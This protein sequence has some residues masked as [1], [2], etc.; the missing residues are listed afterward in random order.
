MPDR[1][2]FIADELPIPVYSIGAGDCDGQLMIVS[3]MLGIF[4]AF[5]PKFVKKYAQIGSE[6]SKAFEAYVADVRAGE[7]PSEEYTY[8][9]LGGELEKLMEIC[10]K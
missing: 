1:N 2:S 10:G 9:M 6:M 7:F 4:Q 5:T 8:S 3:D